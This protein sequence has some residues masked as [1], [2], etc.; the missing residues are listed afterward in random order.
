MTVLN[1]GLSSQ[2]TLIWNDENRLSHVQDSN[3]ATLEQYWYDVDGARV[4]K[5]SGTTT[6]YT[7]FAHY[8]EEVAGGVTTTVSHYSFGGLRIA[9]KRGERPLPP[10]RRPPRQ[11][12]A[13][14]ATAW[15]PR[16]PAAPTTPT[17]P[18]APRRAT[19]R[20]TAPSLARSPTPQD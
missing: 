1:K 20:P 6:T 12:L 15:E 14:H 13:D 19:S 3:G 4:K 9:V 8:E 18:S 7:F 2:R 5:T 16:Q 11:R 17:E 10:A